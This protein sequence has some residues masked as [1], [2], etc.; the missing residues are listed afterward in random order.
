M[1]LLA[2]D[3]SQQRPR[4]AGQFLRPAH[5]EHRKFRRTKPPSLSAATIQSVSHPPRR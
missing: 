4:F 3:G 1:D 2:N 5:E